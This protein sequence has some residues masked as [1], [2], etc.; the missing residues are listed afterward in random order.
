[1]TI[2]SIRPFTRKGKLGGFVPYLSITDAPYNMK[3]GLGVEFVT[4][5]DALEF[6]KKRAA[7]YHAIYDRAIP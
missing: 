4:R 2:I 1:M 5:K 7:E 3:I 6:A